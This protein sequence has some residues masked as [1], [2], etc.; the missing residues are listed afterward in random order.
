MPDPMTPNQVAQ[1][2]A[3]L[4]RDLD[5]TVSQLEVADRDS[6]EKRAGADLAFSRAFI[7][8]VGSVDLR[9]HTA[10]VETHQQRL[11]ADVADALVRHLRRR[12]DAI[13]TRVEVGR[14]LGAAIRTELNLAGHGGET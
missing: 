8:A 11:D 1:Q 12:V 7:A 6:T 5:V 3:A 2:L 10:L 14:S 4:A 9:K 13:K